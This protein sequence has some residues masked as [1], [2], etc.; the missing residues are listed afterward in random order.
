MTW[1]PWDCFK[2]FLQSSLTVNLSKSCACIYT[3]F[4]GLW[5][6]TEHLLMNKWCMIE[7]SIKVYKYTVYAW[8]NRIPWDCFTVFLQSSLKVSLPVCGYI[9]YIDITSRAYS[10]HIKLHD[11]LQDVCCWLY[12]KAGVNIYL[13]LTPDFLLFWWII[14][15][16][17][18]YIVIF[19][20]LTIRLAISDCYS[21]EP[22]TYNKDYYTILHIMHK[23]L[24]G[25]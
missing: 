20:G 17:H 3:L 4:L 6:H 23:K 9:F 22:N 2:V 24:I 25:N 21:E 12:V 16:D 13:S 14:S 11:C 10:D 18:M 5:M 19:C 8:C 7:Y 15:G 1:T